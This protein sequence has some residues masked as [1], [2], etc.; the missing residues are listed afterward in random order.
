MFA[1]RPS[2]A[3]RGA[4][5]G[6]MN[7]TTR[8]G[9]QWYPL[10]RAAAVLY[11]RSARMGVS[12]PRDSAPPEVVA[13]CVIATEAWMHVT[14]CNSLDDTSRHGPLAVAALARALSLL[15]LSE[16]P[17]PAR[18]VPPCGPMPP[19]SWFVLADSLA[20]RVTAWGLDPD[21]V[22]P[23]AADALLAGGDQRL[24]AMAGILAAVSSEAY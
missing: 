21:V 2:G 20:T 14:G 12:A 23:L 1:L 13:A 17:E 8:F 15:S 7:A 19:S 10:D 5:A 11:A 22:M 24:A 6:A 18:E 9:S 16:P 4:D 3:G